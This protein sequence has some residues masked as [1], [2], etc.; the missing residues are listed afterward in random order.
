MCG[1][2]TL[3]ELRVLIKWSICLEDASGSPLADVCSRFALIER[4]LLH[5]LVEIRLLEIELLDV[6]V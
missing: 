6:L 2:G 5:E 3:A 1:V 4:H